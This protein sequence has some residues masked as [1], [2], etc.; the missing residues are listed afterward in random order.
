VNGAVPVA[1][2]PPL[3]VTPGT[4]GRLRSIAVG[5]I[6]AVAAAALPDGVDSAGTAA[7]STPREVWS[8]DRTGTAASW[9]AR[10]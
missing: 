2:S 8:P 4:A 6:G 3:V 10:S 1:P 7:R 5:L 9:R